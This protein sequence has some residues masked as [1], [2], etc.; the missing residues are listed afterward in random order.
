MLLR[1][2]PGGRSPELNAKAVPACAM[3]FAHA[4]DRRPMARRIDAGIHGIAIGLNVPDCPPTPTT[5]ARSRSR[6]SAAERISASFAEEG[7]RPIPPGTTRANVG[8]ANA[9]RMSPPRG[10]PGNLRLWGY[11]K[12]SHMRHLNPVTD[13]GCRAENPGEPTSSPLTG[14][15]RSTVLYGPSDDRRWRSRCPLRAGNQNRARGQ[16]AKFIRWFGE[17]LIAALEAPP[18]RGGLIT[19]PRRGTGTLRCRICDILMLGGAR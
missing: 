3:Q 13:Q 8:P 16:P 11:V 4:C 2:R 9:R 17:L 5:A 6:N 12:M 19:Q 7:Q 14:A 18:V 1:H 15:K 10:S